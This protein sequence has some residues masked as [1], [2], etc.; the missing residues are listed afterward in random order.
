MGPSEGLSSTLS[1]AVLVLVI[2]LGLVLVLGLVSVIM[3]GVAPHEVAYGPVR[4]DL[5]HSGVSGLGLG[6]A[7]PSPGPSP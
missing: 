4:G 7:Q 1:G 6:G 3:F 2:V 5:Q